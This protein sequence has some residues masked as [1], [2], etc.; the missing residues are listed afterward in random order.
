MVKDKNTIFLLEI[1]QGE[2]FQESNLFSKKEDEIS[3]NTK[4]KHFTDFMNLM[5]LIIK[6]SITND[7]AT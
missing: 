1:K 4:S 3:I 2:R 5:T 6:Q 7:K